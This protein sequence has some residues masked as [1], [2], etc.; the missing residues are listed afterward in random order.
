MTAALLWSLCPSQLTRRR[1]RGRA[2]NK[3]WSM[4]WVVTEDPSQTQLWEAADNADPA[5][6]PL[7]RELFIYLFTLAP[8][9]SGAAEIQTKERFNQAPAPQPPDWCAAMRV[10]LSGAQLPEAEVTRE[11]SLPLPSDALF[12]P[13][14]DRE[15]GK[16]H[17]ASWTFSEEI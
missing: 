10:C 9:S 14:W 16:G 12:C 15:R 7:P 17:G 2:W 8:D 11:F 1:R 3:R 6:P 5:L 13:R 4:N